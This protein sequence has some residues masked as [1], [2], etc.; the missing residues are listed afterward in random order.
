MRPLMLSPASSWTPASGVNAGVKQEAEDA[1]NRTGSEGKRRTLAARQGQRH[2]VR[3]I[4][5]D[6]RMANAQVPTKA[7]I[8]AD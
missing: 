3:R 5:F 6:T 7:E 8:T 2:V 4:R 1:A